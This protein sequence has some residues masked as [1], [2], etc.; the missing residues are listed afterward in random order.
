MKW[1]SAGG[2]CQQ[3]SRRHTQLSER[4]LV[5]NAAQVEPGRRRSSDTDPTAD[6]APRHVSSRDHG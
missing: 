1:L 6:R 3:M 2:A 5:K 4:V